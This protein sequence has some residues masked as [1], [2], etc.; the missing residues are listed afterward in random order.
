MTSGG[1]RME[2]EKR[3]WPRGKL[4]KKRWKEGGVGALNSIPQKLN[5]YFVEIVT[6]CILS[7]SLSFA[8][9]LSTRSISSSIGLF[10]Y[11]GCSLDKNFRYWIYCGCMAS[12]ESFIEPERGGARVDNCVCEQEQRK[13]VQQRMCVMQL[14]ELVLMHIL[15]GMCIRIGHKVQRIFP[16]FQC[17]CYA[18]L[19]FL[20]FSSSSAY[21]EQLFHRR[22]FIYWKSNQLN[23]AIEIE[24]QQH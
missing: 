9:S 2:S 11:W 19:S 6:H 18:Y 21:A 8:L 17:C 3:M 10:M 1:G 7:L 22:N 24:R 20:V 12:L 23:S 4:K 13:A 5:K 15:F 16:I 14:G